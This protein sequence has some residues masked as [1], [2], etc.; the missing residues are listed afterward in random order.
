MAEAVRRGGAWIACRAGCNECCIGPFAIS[1]SEALALREG[2]SRSEA[3]RARRVRER[4]AGYLT[5]IRSYD[6]D[7]LPEGMDE[8]PCPALDPATGQCDLY[9]A[10]PI[11]CRIFGP[12]VVM[13]IGAISTCEL[14][15]RGATDEQIAAAAVPIA[16]ELLECDPATATFVAFALG[17]A[18]ERNDA[19]KT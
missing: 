16:P 15:F 1:N 19:V 17:A 13:P 8:V 12:A 7:G 5:S 11:T 2:L 3:A 10:R 6:E 9:E 4:A 14:C 18:L